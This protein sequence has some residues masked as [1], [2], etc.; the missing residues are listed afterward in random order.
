MARD[1]N[2]PNVW[3][4][5]PMRTSFC[6][7]QALGTGTRTMEQPEGGADGRELT[8]VEQVGNEA[9]NFMAELFK[10]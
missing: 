7:F 5:E 1:P 4:L 8:E 6:D 10:E 3:I 2:G 9:A